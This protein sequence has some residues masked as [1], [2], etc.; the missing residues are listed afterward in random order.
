[1]GGL[2]GEA[3]TNR[4]LLVATLFGTGTWGGALGL[5]P[6]PALLCVPVV[7]ASVMAHELGHLTAGL[8][9]RVPNL[10]LRLGAGRRVAAFRVGRVPVELRA[11]PGSGG[12]GHGAVRGVPRHVAMLAAG[13]A[14]NVALV[15][16]G[17]ALLRPTPALG[18]ALC[19]VNAFQGGGA[20]FDPN[21]RNDGTKIRKLLRG[22]RT[23]KRVRALEPRLAPLRAARQWDAMAGVYAA[24]LAKSPR[25]LVLVAYL[26]LM[27]CA[28]GKPAGAAAVYGQLARRDGPRATRRLARL[29][30]ADLVLTYPAAMP[31]SVPAALAVAHGATGCTIVETY[32]RA[33]AALRAGDAAAAL[34]G[35]D[36]TLALMRAGAPFSPHGIA[37][38]QG[39]RALALRSLGRPAEAAAAVA[40]GRA[41]DPGCPVPDLIEEYEATEPLAA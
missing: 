10:A 23:A 13:P 29:S 16:A 5:G 38:T 9:L 39:I 41:A 37:S 25:D 31:E 6:W 18:F 35:A 27:L 17:L 34:A 15:G 22:A 3:R 32:L 21:E 7:F 30:W 28:A 4:W 40:E 19:Y 2:P 24:E 33:L 36:A 1:M 11:W 26:A 14:V 12:V 8:A 20:L